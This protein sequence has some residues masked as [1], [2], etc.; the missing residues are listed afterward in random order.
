M[1]LADGLVA[2]VKRDCPT[3]ELIAPVLAELRDRAGMP[4]TVYSQDDPNFPEIL[5][6]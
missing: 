6:A 2:I 5:G 3:C 1:D 4:L